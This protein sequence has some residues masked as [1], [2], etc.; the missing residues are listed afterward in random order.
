[1]KN[2]AAGSTMTVTV[3]QKTSPQVD[4]SPNTNIQ[5][6]DGYEIKKTRRSYALYRKAEAYQDR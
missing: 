2:P 6:P 3:E 4:V 1:M 5:I